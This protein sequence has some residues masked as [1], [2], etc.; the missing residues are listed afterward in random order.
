MS[1]VSTFNSL[2]VNGWQAKNNINFIFRDVLTL[3]PPQAGAEFSRDIG[4]N[5]AGN[6]IIS[7]IPRYDKTVG[8]I[9]YTDVGAVCV[10][11]G[12]GNTWTQDQVLTGSGYANLDYQG[13]FTSISG[14]GNY[15]AF[16]AQN[17]YLANLSEEG[18]VYVFNSNG[19]AYNQQVQLLSSGAAN[20]GQFGSA[21]S[22]NEYG[23]YMCVGAASE[24]VSSVKSGAAYIFN[25]SG[26]TW[27][28][29]QRLVPSDPSTFLSFGTSCSIDS[30]GSYAIIGAAGS[31]GANTNSGAAYIF[32]RT[33]SA[34]TQVQKL[35]PS[36]PVIQ[37]QFFGQEVAISDNGN[38]IVVS[39]PSDGVPISP[40][41]G[42]SVWIYAKSGG[43]WTEIQRLDCIDPT[44]SPPNAYGLFGYGLALDKNGD[45]LIISDL[46]NGA[47]Y[48]YYNN[49]G[50]FN[51]VQ[52][53]SGVTEQVVTSAGATY[54][55]T[56]NPNGEG[57]LSVYQQI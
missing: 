23:N 14:D 31:D 41:G 12:S 38:I 10:F 25:R 36:L 57:S 54:I 20:N 9:N 28:Q 3:T 21:I 46:I 56:N 53:I 49:L 22:L 44:Y 17:G 52:Q 18:S 2:S 30:T 51:F 16:S 7:G 40:N 48:V 35:T 26:T 24:F 11:S 1:F 6:I 4:I 42:G 27:S 33:G 45:W 34:W 29:Q 37:N 32:T 13:F 43:T 55:L 50:T 8:G 19:T 39:G 5:Y 15:I 47:T